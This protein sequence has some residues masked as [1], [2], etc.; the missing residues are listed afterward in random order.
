MTGLSKD[1]LSRLTF[2]CALIKPALAGMIVFLTGIC[3]VAA[4]KV[5][6]QDTTSAQ[7]S[8]LDGKSFSGDLG[9]FG[10]PATAT[11]LL[12][13]NDGMFVSKGC[14][15]RCGYTAAKYQVQVEGDNLQVESETPCLKSDA[16]IQ[17]RGTVK[18]NQIEGTF[19]WV[20][21]RWYW[22]FEKE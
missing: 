14:E 15:I 11:D 19:T 12:V 16:V 5:V 1:S 18:G 9:P 17:W 2:A 10:K 8:F 21:K 7:L 22:T 20:N 4:E 13:F 6:N 3:D